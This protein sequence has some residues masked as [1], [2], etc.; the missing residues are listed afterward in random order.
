MAQA[1]SNE[2]RRKLLTAHKRG[3][4]SLAQLAKRFAVSLG[5]AKKISAAKREGRR[6]IAVGTTTVRVLESATGKDPSGELRAGS[7]W[8]D[9]FITK[10]REGKELAEI[11]QL[12]KAG[13]VAFSDDGAPVHDAELIACDN[14]VLAGG[15]NEVCAFGRENGELAWKTQVEGKARGLVIADGHLYVSTDKGR[16]Y[17]FAA[18][19]ADD[20]NT[21]VVKQSRLVLKHF[22]LPQLPAT[23]HAMLSRIPT[24]KDVSYETIF[25]R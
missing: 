5:W 3:E 15:Q 1:Y 10:G 19:S 17:G 6:V 18:A 23:R 12:V 22:S 25:G 2:L 20:G 24:S 14:L 21:R 8:T 7:G 4:G 16:I 13:A 11:G 9:L